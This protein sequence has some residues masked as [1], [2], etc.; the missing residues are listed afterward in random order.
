MSQAAGGKSVWS[1]MFAWLSLAAGYPRLQHVWRNPDTSRRPQRMMGR[2]LNRPEVYNHAVLSTVDCCYASACWQRLSQRNVDGAA[3]RR[4]TIRL[5]GPFEV[6]IDGAPVTTFEY[7]KVRALLAYLAVEAARAHPRAELATLLWPDQ[8]E[9]SARG[10]LSQALTT[11]RNALD[12]KGRAA[13]AADRCPQCSARSG[14]A[15]SRS[16]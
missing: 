12:D 11:L 15:R 4:I 9:R 16:M 14:A 13:A 1:T 3:M 6:T 2:A 10:S 7:A 8:P 5:L